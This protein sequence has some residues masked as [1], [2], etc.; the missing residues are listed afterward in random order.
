MIQN[1]IPKIK[2][3]S[4]KA[5]NDCYIEINNLLN[6]GAI[7]RCEPCEGQFLSSYFLRPKN[8]GSNRFILNLTELNFFME[9]PHFKMEDLRTAIK[10]LAPGSFM[11]TID[12]KDAYLMVPISKKSRRFL[13]FEFEGDLY[14]FLTLPFGLCIAPY[15]FTK[16]MKPIIAFLRARGFK[17]SVYL[18]DWFLVGNTELE[19]LNNT[20]ETKSLLQKLGFLINEQKGIVKPSTTV[21][22]LGRIIDSKNLTIELTPEKRAQIKKLVIEM[23]TKNKVRI[24]E[25]AS[26]VGKLTDACQSVKYGWVYVK[27]LERAKNMAL[28]SNNFNYK[29]TME[30]PAYLAEDWKWWSRNI[31]SASM[32]FAQEEYRITIFTDASKTGW[33]ATNSNERVHGAWNKTEKTYHINYLELLAVKLALESLAGESQNCKILLRVDNTTAIAYVNKMGGTQ[34]EDLNL[35][36][37]GIWQWAEERNLTLYASYIKSKENVE[38][39]YLSRITNFDT[40]WSL[41]KIAFQKITQK[42]GT[43]KVDLFASL[44]NRKCTDYVSRFPE[45]EAL[46]TDAFTITWKNKEFYAFPPFALILKTIAKIRVEKATGIVVVPDW[47]NQPWYP[48]FHEMLIEKPVI[49][50]NN[51]ILMSCPSRSQPQPPTQNLIAGKLSGRHLQGEAHL[52][53]H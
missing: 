50:E 33:G 6:K 4:V 43:P 31:Q 32:S 41:S 37:R 18:D 21:K 28:Q 17:S 1:R 52:L 30:V 36:A 49:L 44:N 15:I 35:L 2:F 38:A 22:Y 11:A 10:L 9:S 51:K 16:L 26:L 39:D 40:E 3:E 27:N 8:D 42:L 13:R 12:I 25:F 20:L 46:E 14:E 7:A 45:K 19:C 48:L 53:K 47:P 5:R 34:F 23:S 29:A 24:Q